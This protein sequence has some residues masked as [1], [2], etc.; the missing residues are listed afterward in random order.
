M[1]QVLTLNKIAKCGTDL[2]DSANYQ[3]SDESA[4]PDCIVLRSF[5]MHEMELGS[6][7]ASVARAGAGV[8]NIPIDK[9]SEKGI[10]V[11]N[12]PGANANAVKELVLAGLFLSARKISDG[13]EWA[14]TLK[15]TEGVA[16][17][18]EKGKSSFAGTEI[19]GKK[20]A[21]IGLGAI[22][23]L[24]ANAAYSL[25]MDVIGYDPYMSVKAALGL[26]RHIHVVNTLE[27]AL[28]EAD[29]ITIHVPLLDSTKGLIGEDAFKAMKDGVHLLNFSRGGLVN[30]GALKAA[31]E[32]GKVET[33]ITDFP[34]E[35]VLEL[36]HTICIPH[37]GA[38]SQESEDNCAMMAVNQTVDF[39]EN[40]NI[41]NSVN[42]PQAELP[43]NGG[44][45]VTV[46]HK[47][48][49]NMV[50]QFSTIFADKGMNIDNMLNK[51]R[52]DL[53]Y[54]IIDLAVGAEVADDL[55][56]AIES[57]DGVIK[58]RVID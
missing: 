8:N 15:G 5:N 30:N 6:N 4:N 9:C 56:K 3:I 18:V 12:T 50:A 35:E 40:G 46:S 32:A 17:A 37:L 41:V 45:R 1:Y 54:T 7:L 13:I 21:V 10:V 49:P 57:I 20:L 25:G 48:V 19:M 26:T 36:D 39:M 55:T 29:Y 31:I 42:F 44:K 24:V 51:S 28:A 43:R 34:D 27:D 38:S 23:A 33:Y 2:F 52:G 16:K 53:A 47:N 11:F 58:V 22:G 14:K